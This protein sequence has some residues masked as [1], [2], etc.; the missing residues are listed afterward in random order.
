MPY[1][2]GYRVCK[3]L[4]SGASGEVWMA[5]D[6]NLPRLVA[7]KMLKVGAEPDQ[8]ARALAALRHDAHLLVDVEHPDVVRVYTWLT[9]HEQHYL[10]LQHVAGGSLG[11]RRMRW[12]AVPV[13][14]LKTRR[15][16]PQR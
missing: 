10:V 8:R 2:P 12:R 15:Q 16:W 11:R 4:G 3:F 14:A 13:E 7:I 1:L 6:L 9:V 5:E